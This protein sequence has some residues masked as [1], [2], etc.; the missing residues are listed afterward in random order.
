MRFKVLGWYFVNVNNALFQWVWS[1]GLNA[2][3]Y[4]NY[5]ECVNYVMEAKSTYV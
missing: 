3:V 1:K 4:V 5:I 2:T